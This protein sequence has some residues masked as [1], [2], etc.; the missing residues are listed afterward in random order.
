MKRAGGIL[1]R[2]LEWDNL[3]LA[4]QNARRGLACKAV[5]ERYARNLDHRLSTLRDG[6]EDATFD[7]GS[8]HCFVVRDPK[9]RLIHAPGFPAR[10]AHH[11]IFNICEPLLD[12]RLPMS[13]YACRKGMGTHA[14]I[15]RAAKLAKRYGWFLQLDVRKFFDSIPQKDLLG[16]LGRVF[17]EEALLALFRRILGGYHSNKGTGVGLPIGS[18]SSQHFANLYLASLDRLVMEGCKVPGYVRYMDDF[19]LWGDCPGT[20]MGA[21]D[22]IIRHLGSLGLELK[23]LSTPQPAGHGLGFLGHRIY[24]HRII[25][26]RRAR[27]RFIRKARAYHGKYLDGVVSGLGFQ[28]GLDALSGFGRL[29]EMQHLQALLVREGL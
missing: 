27:T 14:A 10:V 6:L 25:L 4:Y 2:V 20:L 16:L 18:L 28:A 21:R 5:A 24:P 23:H 29:A 8:Y 22:A 7:F 13:A 26:G 17:K 19:V 11:A 1:P 15:A 9:R 12:R 3:L